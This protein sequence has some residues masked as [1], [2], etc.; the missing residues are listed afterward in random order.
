MRYGHQEAKTKDGRLCILG[1]PIRTR[2]R[3][4]WGY[5][6]VVTVTW[7][8]EEGKRLGSESWPLG[9]LNGKL[10]PLATGNSLVWDAMQ[11][12]FIRHPAK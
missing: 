12:R 4:G 3:E 11:N 8:D 5:Y 9:R 7:I 2:S 1:K 10:K 6:N